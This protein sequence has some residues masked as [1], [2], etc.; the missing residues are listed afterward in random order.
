MT[1]LQQSQDGRGS[2]G[3]DGDVTVTVI[4]PGGAA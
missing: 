4:G 1:S 2:G 3:R